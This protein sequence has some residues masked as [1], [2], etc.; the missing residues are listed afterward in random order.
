MN[1]PLRQ[2]GNVYRPVQWDRQFQRGRR[3]DRWRGLLGLVFKRKIIIGAAVLALL[4]AVGMIVG[5][6]E[7]PPTE[8]APAPADETE[9]LV[10]VRAAE[11]R[12]GFGIIVRVANGTV[13][14]I[15]TV[16]TPTE[17]MAAESVARS[18]VGADFRIDNRL[19]IDEGD[20]EP[21]EEP[22]ELAA[23]TDEDLVLQNTIS[24]VLARN[25]IT[26]A[27]ASADID[28]ESLATLD[29]LA[30]VLRESAGQVLIAGHTDT[31]GDPRRKSPAE[32]AAS[33]GGGELSDRSRDRPRPPV[34]PGL[35]RR[36]SGGG[37]HHQR[38]QSGQPPHR[39]PAQTARTGLVTGIG[40]PCRETVSASTTC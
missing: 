4:V 37:Q 5:G 23:V 16:A 9:A 12:A 26:F 24:S 39:S 25:P 8:P 27:S 11:A 34:R 33:R 2:L 17:R 29:A 7:L 3:L 22:N 10:A 19:L 18:V 13:T 32:P 14:L 20:V 21:E 28:P 38:G 6:E 31:D 15:G 40:N 36:P 30:D 35:R 1:D